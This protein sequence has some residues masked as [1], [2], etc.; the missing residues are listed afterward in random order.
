MADWRRA[1]ASYV[2]GRH[3]GGLAE[4]EE[5]RE[6][7]AAVPDVDGTSTSWEAP[8]PPIDRLAAAVPDRLDF[9][10]G[11]GTWRERIA[12]VDRPA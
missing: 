11:A 2:E 8:A 10:R 1:F 3:D 4:S 6:E 9:H 5:E 12:D 7:E